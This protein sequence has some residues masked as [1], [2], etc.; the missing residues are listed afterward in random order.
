MYFNKKK[1]LNWSENIFPS[2]NEELVQMLG[3][4]RISNLM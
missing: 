1:I 2:F 4:L 3:I